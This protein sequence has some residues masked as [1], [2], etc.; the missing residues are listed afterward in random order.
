M[1]FPKQNTHTPPI[2]D[3]GRVLA[4]IWFQ[5]VIVVINPETGIVEKEY[6][7][8]IHPE[9]HE[10]FSV[11]TDPDCVALALLSSPLSHQYAFFFLV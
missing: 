2:I 8:G 5:D 11:K 3:R 9:K 10:D 7:T 4:N 1:F 6:G